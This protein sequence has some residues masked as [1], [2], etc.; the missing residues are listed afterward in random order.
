[1]NMAYENL[2]LVHFDH[3]TYLETILLNSFRKPLRLSTNDEPVGFEHT[4][5]ALNDQI[6]ICTTQ[7][8]TGY[9]G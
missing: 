7:E 8:C 4:A 6:R 3:V 5:M 2:F 9:M 1:M